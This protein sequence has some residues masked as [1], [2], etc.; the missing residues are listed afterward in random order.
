MKIEHKFKFAKGQCVRLIKGPEKG[1]RFVVT[2]RGKGVT[3]SESCEKCDME[4]SSRTCR[5]FCKHYLGPNGIRWFESELERTCK[6][7]RRGKN[8][9]KS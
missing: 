6:L 5:D 3:N 8:G 2:I 7:N 4:H 1:L 9:R